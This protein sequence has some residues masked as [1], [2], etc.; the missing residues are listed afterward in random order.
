M[1]ISLYFISCQLSCVTVYCVFVV[2]VTELQASMVSH[3]PTLTM[4]RQYQFWRILVRQSHWY[5]CC[6]LAS[7]H[8]LD[9]Q[10]VSMMSVYQSPP[11]SST[12]GFV[13]PTTRTWSCHVLGLHVVVPQLLCNSSVGCKKPVT[14]KISLFDFL[15]VSV[16]LDCDTH[17]GAGFTLISGLVSELF[18]MKHSCNC[19][20]VKTS[21]AANL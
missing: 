12:H 8:I 4:L 20:F 6:M 16:S 13:L 10:S 2:S 7:H 18:I 3:L 15:H 17:C 9:H 14:A 21:R 19:T 11:S 5:I 1:F